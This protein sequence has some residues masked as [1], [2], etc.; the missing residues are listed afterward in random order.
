MQLAD[1]GA[2]VIKVEDPTVGGDVA[3]HV[4][5]FQVGEH[6]LYFESFNR[7]KRSIALDLRHPR[8]RAVLG[9]VV[10]H[11]DAVF[12]NL[13]GDQPEPLGLRYHQLSEFN[14]LVVTC[15]L[16]GF[17]LTGP[18]AAEGAYDH[19]IQGLAGWQSLT[20]EPNGSPIKSALSFVAFSAGY[21]AALAIVAAVGPA[22]RAGLGPDADVS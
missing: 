13:R 7:N 19:T 2:D 17:G 16:S 21:V 12:C 15:S 14:P 11:V 3:R 9:D 20:G 4:P 5:P 1:L 6:S 10:R 8:S 18:R 22:R